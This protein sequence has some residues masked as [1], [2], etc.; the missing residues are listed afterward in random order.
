LVLVV[1]AQHMQRLVMA[2]V[3]GMQLAHMP[4]PLRRY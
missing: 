4:L 3:A 1:E 2:A